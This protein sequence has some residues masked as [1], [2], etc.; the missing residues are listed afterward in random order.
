[1]A[2]SFS[3]QPQYPNLSPAGSPKQSNACEYPSSPSAPHILDHNTPPTDHSSTM[4]AI[5]NSQIVQALN[6]GPVAEKARAEADKT[7]R[8]FASLANSRTTPQ[9]STATGQNLTHYHSFFYNLLS[10]EQPRATAISYG[11]IVTFIFATRYLPIIPYMLRLTWIVLGVTAGAEILGQVTLGQGLA[12]KVRPK[13]YYTIPRE[14]LETILVDVEQLINFFVIEFQRIIYAENVYTTV[15]AFVSSF[16]TYYLIKIMPVWGLTLFFTTLVFFLPL[17]YTQNK[18]LIDGQ[19][20]NVST[21]VNE[22]TSQVRE[23]AQHHTN[24][25]LDASSK[26]FKEY[27]ARA[28]EAMGNAKKAAV[29]KGVISPSTA[30]KITPETPVKSADFPAAPKA[31]PVIPKA[32]PVM[33]KEEPVIPTEEPIAHAEVPVVPKEEP[34]VSHA[35]P[36]VDHV[37]ADTEPLVAL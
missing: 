37:K 14:T 35:E 15:A 9:S 4:E 3:D 2:D 23:L 20:E 17:I 33:P 18:E 27:S 32:E 36:V 22:Q 30:E 8:E 31:E 28:Q 19:I 24:R 25:A 6:N 12:S 10:W 1:M 26:T 21:L 7:N 5:A 13:K 11:A 29:D 16:A 34:I